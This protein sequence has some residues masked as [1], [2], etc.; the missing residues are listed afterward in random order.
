MRKNTCVVLN[1][2]C[3]NLLDSKTELVHTG[4]SQVSGA[5]MTVVVL[6]R[7]F[8]SKSLNMT[9]SDQNWLDGQMVI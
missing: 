3:G 1:T 6:K 4:Y 2:I 8:C 5:R 7:G 9:V